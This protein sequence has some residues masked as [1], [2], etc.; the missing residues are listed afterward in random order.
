[1]RTSPPT[2]MQRQSGL[3]AKL[4]TLMLV[5]LVFAVGLDLFVDTRSGVDGGMLAYI[6]IYR[7]PMV[8]YLLAIWAIRTALIRIAAG[9]AFERVMPILLTRVGLALALGATFGVFVSPLFLR[10]S[11][12]ARFGA[13]AN[14]DPAAITVGVVG[15]MLMTLARLFARAVAMRAELDEIL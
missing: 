7:A 15:L 10:L 9:S 14:F 12:G 11:F 2:E 8:F 6:A 13:F 3:F 5:I 4:A 1:M